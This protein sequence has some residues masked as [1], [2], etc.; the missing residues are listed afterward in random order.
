MK[1]LWFRPINKNK[2]PAIK[3]QILASLYNCFSFINFFLTIHLLLL[4][5]SYII[6]I[7]V[8]YQVLLRSSKI[9]KS[10]SKEK[11]KIKTAPQ[12]RIGLVF[13]VLLDVNPLASG[14]SLSCFWSETVGT[15]RSGLHPNNR[16]A[17]WNRPRISYFSF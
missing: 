6:V 7:Y 9:K 15:V 11:V 17:D 1:M 10:K 16:K 12:G 3:K 14:Y 13:P 2:I 4:I 8:L 5:I